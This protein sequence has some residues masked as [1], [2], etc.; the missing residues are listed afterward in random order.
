MAKKLSA[1]EKLAR[2]ICWRGFL[3]KPPHAGCHTPKQYWATVGPDA[4]KRYL[5]HA[6]EIIWWTRRLGADRLRLAVDEHDAA[7]S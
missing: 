1:T 3:T 4:K 6:A 2:D 5:E 7:L